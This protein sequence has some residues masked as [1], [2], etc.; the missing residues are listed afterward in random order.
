MVRI[1]LGFWPVPAV[2]VAEFARCAAER[3]DAYR[4]VFVATPSQQ[5]RQAM[6]VALGEDE[7]LTTQN[8]EEIRGEV[9]EGNGTRCVEVC[10][11][12]PYRMDR[13]GERRNVEA[14]QRD[15]RPGIAEGL[16]AE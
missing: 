14:C 2:P 8:K 5:A 1:R 11:C 9:E 13:N 6:Q 16:A 15:L 10:T 4:R 3:R 12:V 7:V